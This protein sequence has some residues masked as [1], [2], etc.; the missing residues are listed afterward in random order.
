[1][2]SEQPNIES[3]GPEARGA[4]PIEAVSGWKRLR[5]IIKVVELRLR[6]VALL[7]VTALIFANWDTI[8]NY[9]DRW[10]RPAST[11]AAAEPGIEYYCPMHP[12]VVRATA[13][14][15]PICGMPLSKRKKGEKEDLPKGVTSRLRLTPLQVAQAGLR[16]IPVGYS[17]LSQTI[18]T[19]GTV[20]VDERGLARISSRT[21]GLARVEKLLVN[22][23]GTTVKQGDV[24]AEIYSPECYQATHELI[25]AQRAAQRAAQ[26]PPG[27]GS[28][29]VTQTLG[30]AREL[31]RSASE[32]LRLWGLTQAQVDAI[33]KEDKPATRIPI[34]APVG[35]VVI[36]K[37]VVEGQYLNEGDTLFELA[38]LKHV[39]VQAQL[40]EHQLALVNIGD[41]VEA[42][43]GAFPGESFAGTL[44]F[45]NPVL[46]PQTRTTMARFDLANP[47]GRLRPG[48]FATVTLEAPMSR[49]P[50]VRDRLARRTSGGPDLM[51]LARLSV[52]QQKTC[53]VT[54]QELGSMGQP[55]P[56]HVG[57]KDLWACCAGC[58]EPLRAEPKRFLAKL[59]SPP[60]DATLVVPETAVIDTGDRQVVF[61]ETE[62]GVFDARAVVLGPRAGDFFP[63]LEGIDMGDRVASH[64]AF[65]LDAETRLNPA[66]G[67]TY[68]GGSSGNNVA[69]DVR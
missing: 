65:L 52:E 38:D 17:E 48:M 44:A 5:I 47:A 59:A 58:E 25:L 69:A 51:K 7:A 20:E 6:F 64:G 11:L 34:L 61:V 66:L 60:P 45:M 28:S 53:L 4:T 32:R 18:K 8:W 67:S 24:L 26:R 29:L 63:V 41:A 31:V 16:T 54:G 30:D 9:I 19:V 46:D 49:A 68:F 55:V 43:V 40:F 1:M 13:A 14:S 22:V 57:G 2:N 50:A 21:K 23:T 62:P 12:S 10:R 35:G 33:L 27:T 37:N 39:W 15:C 36:R 42:R 3:G 56:V